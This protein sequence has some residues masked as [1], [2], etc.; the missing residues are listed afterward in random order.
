MLDGYQSIFVTS[1]LHV[2]LE[3]MHSGVYTEFSRDQFVVRKIEKACSM[4]AID[5][6]DKQNIAVIRGD[7]GGHA[8]CL[9]EDKYKAV[10]LTLSTES[11]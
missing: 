1:L 2:A 3:Q 9:T 4:I 5:Q 11:Y 6:A 8:N 10:F 7:R